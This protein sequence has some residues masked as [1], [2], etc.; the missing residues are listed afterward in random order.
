MK[1]KN[2]Y[3][4]IFS[5]NKIVSVKQIEKLRFAFSDNVFVSSTRFYLSFAF[6]KARSLT[7]AIREAEKL[8]D[9]FLNSNDVF[10]VTGCIHGCWV[11]NHRLFSRDQQK[12][13]N[14]KQH[15]NPMNAA[16]LIVRLLNW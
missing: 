13:E 12:G 7:K 15:P 6:I 16:L 2:I 14:K 1:R 8:I 3:H 9:N 10:E 11:N 4:V 5:E